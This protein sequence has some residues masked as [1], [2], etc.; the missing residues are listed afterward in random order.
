MLA[1]TGEVLALAFQ[2]SSASVEVIKLLVAQLT[3]GPGG[4]AVC[5][6][7]DCG[8]VRGDSLILAFHKPSGFFIIEGGLFPENPDGIPNSHTS[9]FQRS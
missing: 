3:L 7:P 6:Q 9:H 8:R 2:A 4:K 5:G 1:D